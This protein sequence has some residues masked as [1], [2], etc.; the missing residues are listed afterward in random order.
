[1]NAPLNTRCPDQESFEITPPQEQG[2]D[3]AKLRI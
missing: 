3:G 1:M 2:T